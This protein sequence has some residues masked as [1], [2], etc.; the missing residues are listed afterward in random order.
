MAVNGF[1]DVSQCVCLKNCHMGWVGACHPIFYFIFQ[2]FFCFDFIDRNLIFYLVT[3]LYDQYVV[4]V[5][6]W[7]DLLC[8]ARS[9]GLGSLRLFCG[10]FL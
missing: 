9:I 5:F 10:V 2:L 7:F 3:P 4:D 8:F 1:C 6:V